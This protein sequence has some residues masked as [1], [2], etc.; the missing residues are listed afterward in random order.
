MQNRVRTGFFL[1]C[2]DRSW[3]ESNSHSKAKHASTTRH[4]ATRITNIVGPRFVISAHV[5]V[6]RDP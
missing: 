6:Q 3:H 2:N 5:L 1:F 4:E